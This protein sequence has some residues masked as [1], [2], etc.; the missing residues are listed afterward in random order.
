MNNDLIISFE[1][2]LTISIRDTRMIPDKTIISISQFVSLTKLFNN[3]CETS[4]YD[5]SNISDLENSLN[6]KLG[7]KTKELLLNVGNPQ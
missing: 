3:I 4:K 1:N 5:E 6:F 7:P 2:G